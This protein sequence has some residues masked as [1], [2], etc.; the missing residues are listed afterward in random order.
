MKH[1]VE[2]KNEHELSAPLCIPLYNILLH[3]IVS[4]C[5]KPNCTV[6]QCIAV[7]RGIVSYLIGCSFIWIFNVSYHWGDTIC[8]SIHCQCWRCTSLS[9]WFFFTG[10]CLFM[11]SQYNLIT[12]SIAC[13]A[14]HCRHQVDKSDSDSFILFI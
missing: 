9:D 14:S 8:I 5:V 7:F 13:R 10:L 1:I 6:S 3:R 11:I 12:I 4:H 2:I